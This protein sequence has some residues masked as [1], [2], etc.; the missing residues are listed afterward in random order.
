MAKKYGNKFK[1]MHTDTS[2]RTYLIE[3]KQNVYKDMKRDIEKYDKSN[4]SKNNAACKQGSTESDERSELWQSNDRIRRTDDKD[5]CV[6]SKRQ[7]RHKETISRNIVGN[8]ITFDYYKHCLNNNVKLMTPCHSYIH[9]ELHNVYT[10]F[11]LKCALSS[12]DNERY[13]K[14]K[15]YMQ[16]N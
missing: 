12:L 14:F 1:L 3:C 15:T 4:Y 6:Q 13:M 16:N 8:S 2:K 5:V 10:V 9:S 7:E 11:K